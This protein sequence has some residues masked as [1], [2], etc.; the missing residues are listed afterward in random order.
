MPVSIIGRA[1]VIILLNIG[2][3]VRDSFFFVAV[4]VLYLT[5]TFNDLH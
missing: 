4:N 1:K 3:S 5:F 2:P